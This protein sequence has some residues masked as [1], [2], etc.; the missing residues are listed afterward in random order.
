MI[1]MSRRPPKGSR[2]ETIICWFAGAPVVGRNWANWVRPKA[3][4]T[5]AMFVSWEKE[6]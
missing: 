6:R 5:D 1:S 2:C 3:V 4:R